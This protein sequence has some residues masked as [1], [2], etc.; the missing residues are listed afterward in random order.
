MTKISLSFIKSNKGWQYNQPDIQNSGCIRILR[1]IIWMVLCLMLFNV[2]HAQEEKKEFKSFISEVGLG[3][4]VDLSGM[5]NFTDA[6]IN[7]GYRES[8]KGGY[9]GFIPGFQFRG[10]GRSDFSI[11]SKIRWG[12]DLTDKYD[13]SFDLGFS[14]YSTRFKE[15]PGW[16]LGANLQHKNQFGIHLRYDEF[17]GN[18]LPADRNIVLGLHLTNSKATNVGLPVLGVIGALYGILQHIISQ[19]K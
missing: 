3:Y 5:D 1:N 10:A 15:F 19:S 6:Y 9:V 18:S 16:T 11:N 4:P 2:A 17:S 7:L 12:R 8:I 14:F 13:L